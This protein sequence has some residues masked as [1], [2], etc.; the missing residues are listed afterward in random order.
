METVVENGKV[1]PRERGGGAGVYA[2]YRKELSDHIKSKRFLIII[3]LIAI[4][5]IASLY[6][7]LGGLPAVLE[8]AVSDSVFLKLFTTGS[9]S[10][11]SFVSFIAL[12]GPLVG[13]TLGFDAI[14]GERSRGTMGRL[15]SQPIYRDSIING[16]FLAGLT[17][18]FIMVASLG[19]IISGVGL[20]ATG[21][22]P[23]G[24]DVARILVFLLF[25]GV[26]MAFWLG[27][28]ILFSVLCKHA[29]TSALAVIA[30]WLVMA[31]FISLLAGIIA[32]G[33]HPLTDTSPASA[34]LENYMT[35]IGVSR[36]SPT[37]LY[38]ESVSTIL[39]PGIRAI[40]IVTQE[41]IS[42]AIVGNLPLSES[43]LLVWPHLTVLAAMTMVSFVV[44]YICFMRQEI[45]A[46]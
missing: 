40:G 38:S 23:S 26:Y 33:L 19:L 42:G 18:I 17:V 39:D 12:L 43:L 46:S 28:S 6:A 30:I 5:A 9:G 21:V 3:A 41:Q 35:E 2:L 36:I 44:S 45:R 20:I 8:E 25:T 24:E 27:L 37:N 22:A 11:P 7:A 31:I 4:T 10:I 32:D 34:Q 14:N 29:A 13:L 15:V 16:K 1:R